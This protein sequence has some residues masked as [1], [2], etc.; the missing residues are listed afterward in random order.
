MVEMRSCSPGGALV[1]RGRIENASFETMT[2]K[3]SP[4]GSVGGLWHGFITSGGIGSRS[5]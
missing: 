4:D 5:V 2:V 1:D 3:P